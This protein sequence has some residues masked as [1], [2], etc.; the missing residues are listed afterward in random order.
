MSTPDV[1]VRLTPEGVAEVVAALKKIQAES[2]AANRSSAGG[3]RVVNEALRELKSLLPALGLAAVVGGFIALTKRATEF[4]DGIGK[5]QQKV[6][7]A[8]EDLSA[9]AVAFRQN[10]SNQEELA[11]LLRQTT[12]R[13]D[14]LRTGSSQVPEELSRIGI[15]FEEIKGLD[16][17]RVFELIAQRLSNIPDEATRAALATG[18]FKKNAADLIP[19]LN[20]VG[21]QGIDPFIQKAKELGLLVDSDFADA[22]A[23]ANDAFGDLKLAAEGLAAQFA[24]GLLPQITA[25]MEG[26]GESIE[27]DGTSKMETFGRVTGI[28]IR[29]IGFAFTSLGKIIGAIFATIGSQ[30]S[31]LFD[32][33]KA[34]VTLDFSGWK[35]AMT[36]LFTETNQIRRDLLDDLSKDFENIATPPDPTKR[37]PRPRN[38]APLTSGPAPEDKR[39]SDARASFLKSQL[40]NELALVKANLQRLEDANSDAY[41]AGLISLQEYYRRRQELAKQ[42]ADAEIRALKTQRQALLATEF[43]EIQ[44]LQKQRET[45]RAQ[46]LG[47]ARAPVVQTPAQATTRQASNL[48]ADIQARTLKLREQIGDLDAKIQQREIEYQ[49]QR[50]SL[51]AEE[52][53]AQREIQDQQIAGL[54][55]LAEL[56]GNRHEAFTLNLAQESRA[57]VELLQRAGASTEEI[58]ERVGRFTRARTSQFNFE[59]ITRKGSAAL[60]SFN[61]DADQIRRD[62]EAGIITQLEGE[63]RLIEL[64][65]SRLD[66]LKQLAAETVRAA[67]ATKTAENPLGNQEQ[68]EQAHRFADSVAEIEASFKGA[69]DAVAKFRQGFSEGLQT[70]LEDFFNNIDKIHSLGEAWR[71]L[72]DTI[73]STLRR[74]AAELL[75]KQITR[76]IEGIFDSLSQASARSSASSSSGGGSGGGFMAFLSTAFKLFGSGARGGGLQRFADGGSTTDAS[77]GGQVRGPGSGT[78][79]SILAI[80]GGRRPVRI[81]NG[82]FITKES[83]VRQ[84]GALAFLRDFNERGMAALRAPRFAAGGLLTSAIA[85]AAPASARGGSRGSVMFAPTIQ[86]PN[87]EAGRRTTKQAAAEFSR[88]LRR[89]D[90]ENN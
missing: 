67:E 50:D 35:E 68:I 42:A 85:A 10:N 69:T 52:A 63:N 54:Q 48:D 18:I 70:G 86:A 83:T 57:I 34:A 6:G 39:I 9:L 33:A 55:Q 38:A 89:S 59:E 22:A 75:S 77:A 45:T 5:L 66:L 61:R 23:K 13:M 27:Q 8:T 19:A 47:G 58:Q 25:A 71:S 78:S 4:A 16:A 81:A 40:D 46:A 3:V 11:G 87:Q 32:A 79:D 12:L 37:A 76:G 88:V 72:G 28:I 43:A 21:Q 26:I 82:E 41:Q 51:L 14:E 15:G 84:P 56:E 90:R 30:L 73:L 53:R 2:A 31:N 80:I 64:Q 65:R 1:R 49:R 29:S 20:A 60:D 17:P 7:G 62:Q 36:R 44:K 74:V 24:V